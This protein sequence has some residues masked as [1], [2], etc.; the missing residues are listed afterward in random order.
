M[1][2]RVWF[3]RMV[4]IVAA[5][6][7]L[8]GCDDDD[9]GDTGTEPNG[10]GPSLAIGA[11]TCDA[12]ECEIEPM[13]TITSDVD[14]DK[15]AEVT[16]NITCGASK[17]AEDIKKAAVDNVA[18]FDKIT[19]DAAI[20]SDTECTANASANLGDPAEEV[21]ATDVTFKVGETPAPAGASVTGVSFLKEDDSDYST[22]NSDAPLSE[23]VFATYQIKVTLD[24]ELG[25][26]ES[27][28]LSWAC[29]DSNDNAT[30]TIDNQPEYT[31]VVGEDNATEH[32]VVIGDGL[33]AALTT[34][35]AKPSAKCTVT[36]KV[37]SGTSM[38]ADIWVT[39][40]ND[41]NGA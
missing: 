2:F 10:A 23:S 39:G 41:A 12:A 7:A 16:L 36:A 1:S 6:V 13:V 17:V 8:S 29:V 21:K 14:A 22:D 26:G 32:T 9:N 30:I 33:N 34:A 25:T 15:T 31:T 3:L 28:D 38:S 35:N 18:T 4:W 5:A 11:L 20:V 40:A 37:G 24:K 27:I 19:L